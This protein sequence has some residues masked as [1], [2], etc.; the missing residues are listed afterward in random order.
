M[1]YLFLK[2]HLFSKLQHTT[3][4]L[5]LHGTDGPPCQKGRFVTM[6]RLLEHCLHLVCFSVYS[7]NMFS[8]VSFVNEHADTIINV[9]VL[10]Q[11]FFPDVERVEWLN[12]V[13]Q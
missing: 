10:F 13:S 1:I 11:V 4:N 12:K 8:V 7:F 9:R 2:T 6:S 3:L 5:A